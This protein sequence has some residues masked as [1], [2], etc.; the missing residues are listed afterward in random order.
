MFNII[1]FGIAT[2]FYEIDEIRTYP[3]RKLTRGEVFGHRALFNC[4]FKYKYIK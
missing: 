3:L 1:E 4:N 2:V